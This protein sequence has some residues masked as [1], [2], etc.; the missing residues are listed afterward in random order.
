M[1]CFHLQRSLGSWSHG[2]THQRTYVPR[3]TFSKEVLAGFAAVNGQYDPESTVVATWWDYGY[4]STFL[5]N[6]PV[7][8]YGGA[9]NTATTHFMARAFLD[10]EQTASFGTMKFL[11]NQGSGGASVI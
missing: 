1:P 10:E 9:V 11:A 3:P 4:A 7:L 6:L 5:N 2:Q 8:H